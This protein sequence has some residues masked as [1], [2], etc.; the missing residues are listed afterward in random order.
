MK[1]IDDFLSKEDF[2]VLKEL[3]ISNRIPY[4][5][6]K[7]VSSTEEDDFKFSYLVHDLY[8]N[9][10]I[11]SPFFNEFEKIILNY[12]SLEIVSL[13]RMK[14]NFYPRT[15]KRITHPRHQDYTLKGFNETKNIKFN[16]FIL[17][18]NTCDGA[19]IVYKDGKCHEVP[20][21]ENRALF[22]DSSLFHSSTNCTNARGRFNININYI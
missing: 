2:K 14:I 11:I 12:K 7:N 9:N 16:G 20:S 17:S 19:T 15:E 18:F 21:V 13:L 3:V 6:S 8:N 22:F 10:K 5:Y 4:Y 1:V